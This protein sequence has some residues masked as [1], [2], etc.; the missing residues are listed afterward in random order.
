MSSL[1]VSQRREKE[2]MGDGGERAAKEAN[3]PVKERVPGSHRHKKPVSKR[4]ESHG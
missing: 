1:K 2:R 4:S 3:D